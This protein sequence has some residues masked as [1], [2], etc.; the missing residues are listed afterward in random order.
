MKF[1]EVLKSKYCW[2]VMMVSLILSYFLIV[3]RFTSFTSFWSILLSVFYIIL[4]SISNSCLIFEIKS[5]VKNK[6][7]TGKTSFISI[8]GSVLGFSAVQLCTV[9]GTCSINLVTTLLFAV[10]PTSIGMIFIK[11]GIW[12]LAIANLLLFYSIYKLECF[13]KK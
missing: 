9:S 7:D 1:N 4:F 3:K 6:L 8:L 11:N 10:L 2:F 5:R 12:V 13:K